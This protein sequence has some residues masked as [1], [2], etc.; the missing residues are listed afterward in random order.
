[1]GLHSL[2]HSFDRFST[3]PLPLVRLSPVLTMVPDTPGPLFLLIGSSDFFLCGHVTSWRL[4]T[5][6]RSQL[7]VRLAV[8]DT[9]KATL[10]VFPLQDLLAVL[11][12]LSGVHD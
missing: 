10:A 11:Q 3:T 2:A 7:T 1:M 5:F 12:L 9:Y 8:K 4:P 6:R